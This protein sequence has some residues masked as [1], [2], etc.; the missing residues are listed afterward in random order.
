[1][2]MG[3]RQRHP[4][5]TIVTSWGPGAE[6]KVISRQGRVR[7][8]RWAFP[9]MPPARLQPGP[10]VEDVADIAE[11]RVV[12]CRMPSA[13]HLPDAL[14]ANVQRAASDLSDH[15][16]KARMEEKLD[17]VVNEVRSLKAYAAQPQ[18][19]D[20]Y[21]TAEVAQMFQLTENTIRDWCR[22]GRVNADK[23]R[24]G[25][26]RHPSWVISHEEIERYRKEGLLP[27]PK[28]R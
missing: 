8:G 10:E 24:S 25:R 16:W 1:M 12:K 4:Q 5:I 17:L 14:G 9:Q 13:N 2:V 3:Y 27:I 22:D 6:E 20:W 23:K 28:R 18:K 7:I 15:A 26:G 11:D 19:Q 21:T